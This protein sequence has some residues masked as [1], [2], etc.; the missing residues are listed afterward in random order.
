MGSKLSVP[1]SASDWDSLAS[2]A[3]RLATSLTQLLDSAVAGEDCLERFHTI[4]RQWVCVK[5]C[6]IA[7]LTLAINDERAAWL[8]NIT[9]KMSEMSSR[10]HTIH[11]LGLAPVEEASGEESLLS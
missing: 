2:E 11:R 7:C 8:N 6:L 9:N 1:V 3:E 4:H 5:G 10:F